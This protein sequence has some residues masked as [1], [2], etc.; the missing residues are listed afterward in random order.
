MVVVCSAGNGSQNLEQQAYYPASFDLKDL[1]VVGATDNFDQPTGWSNWS[2]RK[3]TVAAPG[4]NILTTQ[5]G[6]GYWNVTGT[7]AAAPIVAGIAG[8]LKT[9]HPGANAGLV[10]RAIS[11]GARQIISLSGKVSSSGVVS[12]A[13]AL[14]RL[15]GS[16][17]E[18]PVF[19]RSGIGSGGNGP[20]GSFN[21]TPPPATTGAPEAN[22]PNLNDARKAQP[23][24]PKAQTPPYPCSAIPASPGTADDATT[25]APD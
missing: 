2:A 8:L 19:P 22:M 4:A 17:N 1:I 21:T 15:R 6:G 16:D 3:V 7:S 24:H 20:G 18:P 14:E 9:L 23:Q 25:S 5:R 11:D 10:K 13:G 12:A